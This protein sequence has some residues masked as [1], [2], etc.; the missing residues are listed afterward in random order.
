M[1]PS[2]QDITNP[3]TYAGHGI[4]EAVLITDQLYNALLTARQLYLLPWREEEPPHRLII[5][6]LP[7]AEIRP[8]PREYR[9]CNATLL[10]PPASKRPAV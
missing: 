9:V 4:R 7:V 8:I 5:T 2:N 10:L 1:P 6:A 3:H